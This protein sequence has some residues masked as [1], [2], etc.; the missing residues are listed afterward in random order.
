MTAHPALPNTAEPS[1]DHVGRSWLAA[2]R[3]PCGCSTARLHLVHL[4][5]VPAGGA[6]SIGLTLQ[7]IDRIFRH[8]AIHLLAVG[9]GDSVAIW[10]TLHA[11]LPCP[12]VVLSPTE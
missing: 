10:S 8:F 7:A 3:R 11:F 5:H 1:V 2:P 9:R 6:D 4:L 12:P